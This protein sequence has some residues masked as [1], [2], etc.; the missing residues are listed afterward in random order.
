MSHP[1]EITSSTETGGIVEVVIA[2]SLLCAEALFCHRHDLT[3]GD[4]TRARAVTP[5][6]GVADAG[7]V[8]HL[9]AQA[10]M[11]TRPDLAP[12]SLDE[13]LVENADKLDVIERR[14]V[15]AILDLHNAKA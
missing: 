8:Y 11:Q 14:A 2:A 9:L 15:V 4:I 13:W 6:I 3:R 5:K 1:Y 10:M 7:N 12:R